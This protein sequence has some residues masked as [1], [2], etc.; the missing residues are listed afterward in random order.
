MSQEIVAHA[1]LHISVE[2]ESEGKLDAASFASH[3]VPAMGRSQAVSVSGSLQPPVSHYASVEG[4]SLPTKSAVGG[5]TSSDPH[6]VGENSA[7][8]LPR[9][10]ASSSMQKQSRQP[11]I[12]RA[13]LLALAAR[14]DQN[15]PGLSSTATAGVSLNEAGVIESNTGAA[16]EL[17]QP[18]AAD[19]SSPAAATPSVNCSNELNAVAA[20]QLYQPAAVQRLSTAASGASTAAGQ[21][22]SSSDIVSPGALSHPGGLAPGLRQ[23]PV[24]RSISRHSSAAGAEGS[25]ANMVPASDCLTEADLT[26]DKRMSRH[27][28]MAA[29]RVSSVKKQQQPWAT[30]PLSVTSG[31]QQGFTGVSRGGSA[32]QSRVASDAGHQLLSS[33]DSDTAAF[34]RLATSSFI[35][36]Q[37]SRLACAKE[38]QDLDTAVVTSVTPQQQ[39][40]LE[41]LSRHT[42]RVSSTK[43]QQLPNGADSA[44]VA[45]EQ[46]RTN[47]G[48]D[49]QSSAVRLAS[50]SAEQQQLPT[51]SSAMISSTGQTDFPQRSYSVTSLRV[52][53]AAAVAGPVAQLAA[54]SITSM[55]S[56]AAVS[57]EG[58]GSAG[59]VPPTSSANEL[60]PQ[61]L[62]RTSHAMVPTLDG[63]ASSLTASLSAAGRLQQEEAADSCLE[64]SIRQL[65]QEACANSAT[66]VSSLIANLPA[67]ARLQP[68]ASTALTSSLTGSGKANARLQPEDSSS[69]ALASSLTG[70]G[71]GTRLQQQ[72]AADR[73]LGA[74]LLQLGKEGGAGIVRHS[75]VL[76]HH[77]PQGPPSPH[78]YLFPLDYD[79][80]KADL[81]VRFCSTLGLHGL[82]HCNVMAHQS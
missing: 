25:T 15:G 36:R 13:A 82:K 1:E 34:Q 32:R 23:Q 28:S 12:N 77:L 21:K 49:Q 71:K 55:P 59:S 54:S 66:S 75:V 63:T 42:S 57:A 80:L 10:A 5:Q 38:Q 70:S 24:S 73:A 61:G 9:Q 67:D 30:D 3:D 29:S 76:G 62:S 78:G 17:L 41:L 47:L 52:R 68:D 43:L 16:P 60:M 69:T 39:G 65:G 37:S 31:Q 53:S 2:A 81:Q 56:S 58:A 74:S 35:G 14:R 72:G 19:A 20:R 44:S 27:N 64:P 7:E 18:P 40:G 79:K 11:S 22:E 8:D 6:D 46:P 4:L 48:I 45:S 26:T 51:A 50:S 33:A